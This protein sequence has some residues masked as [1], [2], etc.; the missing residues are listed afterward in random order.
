[1]MLRLWRAREGIAFALVAAAVLIT[2]LS[3]SD[4]WIYSMSL[5]AVYAIVAIGFNV[6]LGQAGQVSFAQ[7]AF[8]AVGA[9]SM[10]LLTTRAHLNPW[11]ALL[12]SLVLGAVLSYLV[13]LPFLRLRG[14]YLGMATLALALGTESFAANATGFTGGAL[15][16]PG[17]PP[18]AIGGFILDTRL[19]FFVLAWTACGLAVLV[20]HLTAH[21]HLGRAWRA[22]AARPDVSASL[23]VNVPRARLLALALAGTMAAVSGSLLAEYLNYV[24]PDYF[25]ITMIG[26]IFFMVIV[27]GMGSTAGPVIGAAAVVVLPQ[28][29]GSLGQWQ[30]VVLLVV[31]LAFLVLWPTGLLG[32]PGVAGSVRNLLPLRLQAGLSRPRPSGAGGRRS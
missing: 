24:A 30:G 15:G 29:M 11:L 5:V 13:N 8:M 7:V 14:H 20:Y 21:S 23:G 3:G 28:E 1:M 32:D 16:V 26:N 17:V 6:T 12:A 18:L 31:L 27:G 4:Y 19:R 25:G 2:G 22:I 10:A 9:Y